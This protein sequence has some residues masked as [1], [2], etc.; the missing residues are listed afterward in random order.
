MG[1]P[2]IKPSGI[3]REE[4]ITD[5]IQSIACMESALCHILNAEGEK[6][7]AVVGTLENGNTGTIAKTPSELLAINKS[8]EK[9][10]SSITLLEVVLQKKLSLVYCGCDNNTDI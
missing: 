7:Q 4:A 5:I 9:M 3:T 10:V 2:V 6:I 8:V 1:M